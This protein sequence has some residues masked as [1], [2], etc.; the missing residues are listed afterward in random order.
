MKGC[1]AQDPIHSSCLPNSQEE[2][3][4]YSGTQSHRTVLD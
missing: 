1:T 2:A 4:L 3:T